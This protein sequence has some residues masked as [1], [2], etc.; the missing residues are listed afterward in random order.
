MACNGCGNCK[1]EGRSAR[2][3]ISLDGGENWIPLSSGGVLV[4]YADRA[5]PGDER[6]GEVMIHLTED[7]VSTSLFALGPLDETTEPDDEK[8]GE[9][10]ESVDAVVGRLSVAKVL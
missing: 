2:S 10:S 5:I 6:A 7:L 1:C 4:R 9:A 8:L 3:L